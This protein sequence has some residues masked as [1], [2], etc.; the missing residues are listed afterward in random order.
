MPYIIRP[1]SLTSLAAV[2]AS[3]MLCFGTGAA[4][5]ATQTYSTA[6]CAAP[7]LS[8]PF[9]LAN[10]SGYYMLAPGQSNGQFNG[11]GWTLSGGAQIA[12]ASLPSGGYGKVLSLPVGAKA[13]SPAICVTT[14]YPWARMRVRNAGAYNNAVNFA[15][16][17]AGS[18]SW[19]TPRS[20][21]EVSGQY[22]W[23]LSQQLSMSPE[24]VEGWQL[25]QITLTATG[26]YGSERVDDL[27]I[28]PYSR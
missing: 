18:S 5:A 26:Y 21:G 25:V 7:M 9:A 2:A 12:Y 11:S 28:D 6:S 8:Q 10:D 17:Y 19:E 14:A 23:T 24:H 13:T 4:Q 15:V 20:E 3:A 1:R 27:Y 22:G 16:G